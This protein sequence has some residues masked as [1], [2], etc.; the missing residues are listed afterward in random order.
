MMPFQ[1]IARRSKNRVAADL[2]AEKI[3][4][5]CEVESIAKYGTVSYA[6]ISGAMQS[7]L[8]FALSAGGPGVIAHATEWL[9][10]QPK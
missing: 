10:E 8:A 2:L 1:W 5:Q 7:H 9:L 6:A 3:Y 4:K